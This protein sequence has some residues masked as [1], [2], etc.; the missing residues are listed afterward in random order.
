MIISKGIRMNE[1]E[2]DNLKT[3]VEAVFSTL[4]EIDVRTLEPEQRKQHQEAL[5]ITYLAVVRRENKRFEDLTSNAIKKLK[6]LGLGAEEL[7]KQLV[8]LTE[9][10]EI[11]E[12]ITNAIGVLK[13]VA[14]ILK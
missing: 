11:L 5:A 12:K 3:S 6:P 4:Y 13:S 10:T 8:G 7:R 2:Y 14:A 1:F 9:S